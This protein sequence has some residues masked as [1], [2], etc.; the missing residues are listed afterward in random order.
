MKTRIYLIV[1]AFIIMALS[2]CAP[3]EEIS[4]EGYDPLHV[5]GG[6]LSGERQA[7]VV[8]DIG[9]GDREYYAFTNGYG[10][11]VRVVADEIVLQDDDNE[12]VLSTGRY[13]RDE[14]KVPGVESP[15]LD[16]GHV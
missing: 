15:D 11:L 13:F 14:A 8:V 5:D 4:F 7:L 16:E 2:S 12:P 6:D 10:Q 1:M 3:V 9:F